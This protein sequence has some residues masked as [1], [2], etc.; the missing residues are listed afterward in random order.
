MKATI[1]RWAPR[2]GAALAMLAT[3]GHGADIWAAGQGYAFRGEQAPQIQPNGLASALQQRLKALQAELF[4]RSQRA[5]LQQA[6]EQSLLQNP[7]LARSYALIQ[8]SKW[9]LIAIRRQWYPTLS[10]AGVGP[11]GGLWG[12]GGSRTRVSAT[13]AAGS[14]DEQR[15]EESSRLAARLNLGWTFFDPSRGA[16]INAA[17]ETLR[18]QELLFNVAAR[19]L[20]L[21][22]QL[23][24]FNLQEQE[25]LIASYE[26][27]LEA[28]TNQLNRVEAL[29]NIG[30]A[31][32][33]DV[34]QIRTQQYQTLSLLITTY[35]D[36]V[37]AAA[38]LAEAMSLAPGQLVLPADK[39]DRYGQWDTP[40]TT[41][42]EQALTLREEI[43][44]SLALADSA[45]W[46]ASALFNRYWP[47]FGFAATG[48][49]DDGTIRA[50]LV[51][52][53]DPDR[54][55]ATT[56]DGAVGIGFNWEIF[57][58]GIAAAEASAQKALARQQSDQAA[59]QRLQV[60]AEVER[61]Y[62][63]YEAS[64]LALQSSDEQA[65]SAEKAAIAVRER[66]NVGYAD[67]TSVVQTLN[68]AITATNA[69]ARS[70]RDYNSAVAG[71]YR[72]SAR[73]P[74]HTLALRNQ[75][76]QTLKQR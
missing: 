35:Q 31:S 1:Q 51:G 55:S 42:I 59:A 11:A 61:S 62:A 18:S 71:L 33:A 10:A 44:S 40:F 76:V 21:K 28:T 68:Q 8:Q 15:F 52:V 58:G 17:S 16:Q 64:L 6:L 2:L 39:L 41:T 30:N 38:S 29:F 45:S 22:T 48:L 47:R 13:T 25:Q 26:R 9:S 37:D 43:R 56:W 65:R 66:F 70:I 12:Y 3:V 7:E 50:G 5:S 67:I 73:W 53:A 72:A 34:E 4:V 75:R 27:I 19:N 24:Y 46:R 63:A 54:T 23:A 57:D 60:S 36:I 49:Y 69:Y 20:A 32:I 14:V 74:D